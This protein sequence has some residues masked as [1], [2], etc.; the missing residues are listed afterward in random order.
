[1]F[2]SLKQSEYLSSMVFFGSLSGFLD[3]P[4]VYLVLDV[5]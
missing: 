5:I 4:E 2:P 1:M 3:D